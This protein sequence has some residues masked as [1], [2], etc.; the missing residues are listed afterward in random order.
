[1]AIIIQKQKLL[2]LLLNKLYITIYFLGLGYPAIMQAQCLSSANPVG[3]IDNLLVLEKQSFRIISFYKY[4]QSKQYYEN[5]RPCNF[6]LIS[7][8]WYNYGSALI[9]YGVTNKLTLETELGYY[10]NKSQTYNIDPPSTLTGQGLS[11]LTFSAKY[12]LLQ[13]H[14][15]RI[16]YS[17]GL[18]MKVP[19]SR[20]PMIVDHVE[21]P[22]ELQPTIGAYG[23]VFHSSYVK[24]YSEKG[25]RFFLTNRVE[26]NWPN[27]DEYRLGT[28]FFNS[29]FISK[30]LMS[31]KLKGDW[32]AI[33]QL[34]NEIRIPDQ[35]ENK[36][37]ESSGS[38]LF[39]VV[40]QIN[41]VHKEKWNFSAMLDIPIYQK[42]KGI[43]L[44]A[45]MGFTLVFS[46]TIKPIAKEAI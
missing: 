35:I 45:G 28:V 23:L 42:F 2:Q 25:L 7:K 12:N 4:G 30:H 18:G 8:A 15:K 44:S 41:Y 26:Y 32:T 43:Q 29:F 1:M 24:E 21:L 10:F 33:A 31:P 11:N 37:K 34:R 13:N 3:G 40:P 22:P 14:V 9:G 5:N 38:C 16:Y 17:A 36:V 20:K 27:K 39:F 19:F 46:R 6:S